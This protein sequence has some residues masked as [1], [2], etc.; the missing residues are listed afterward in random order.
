[1]W[2]F[3]C[4]PPETFGRCEAGPPGAERLDGSR[5]GHAGSMG[6]LRPRRGEAPR[7]ALTCGW[8]DRPAGGQ[9]G[10]AR[11][12]T[13]LSRPHARPLSGLRVWPE[14]GS[15]RLSCWPDGGLQEDQAVGA[16]GN[17]WGV[18]SVF[19]AELRCRAFRGQSLATRKGSWGGR[20]QRRAGVCTSRACTGCAPQGGD[21]HPQPA[22]TPPSPLG[23]GSPVVPGAPNGLR[24]AGLCRPVFVPCP[25]LAEAL[26]PAA[27]P[28]LPAL[29]G[30]CDG[31]GPRAGCPGEAR[32]SGGR[33][34]GPSQSPHLG[35]SSVG[36]PPPSLLEAPGL[37]AHHPLILDSGGHR[38]GSAIGP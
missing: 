25:L 34:P 9:S 4:H 18:R 22:L 30:G 11:P 17:S 16:P 3:L 37:P 38:A 19:R 10:A 24:P 2:G 29:W 26:L 5:R 33:C 12:R 7:T 15:C 8:V 32:V 13:W 6:K 14:T 21:P 1:M 35:F 27:C 31:P 28:D 23:L 20:A 36:C